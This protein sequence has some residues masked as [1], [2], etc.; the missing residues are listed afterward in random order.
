METVC[1]HGA[2][3]FEPTSVDCGKEAAKDLSCWFSIEISKTPI[4]GGVIPSNAIEV[5][6][7]P[8]RRVNGDIASFD[9]S[10]STQ[11]SNRLC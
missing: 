9:L 7:S 3:A 11:S 10:H 4:L 2:A 1:R 6:N 5:K 8:R